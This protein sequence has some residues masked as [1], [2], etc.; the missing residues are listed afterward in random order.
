MVRKTLFIGMFGLSLLL[1]MTGCAEFAVRGSGGLVT[2]TYD[3]SGFNHLDVSSAV[4]VE[5]SQEGQES[6]SVETDANLLQYLEV[7]VR[8]ETL[9]VGLNDRARGVSISPS[10]GIT[11]T[12][13]VDD[14]ERLEVSGASDVAA[15]PLE[16]GDFV[17][18]VSG[19]SDVQIESLDVDSARI[20]ASGASDVSVGGLRAGKLDATA[21]GASTVEVSGEA[22]EQVADIEGASHYRASSLQ[23]EDAYVEASGASD[24]ELR[25]SETLGV[26]ASGA[27]SVGYYG[28]PQVS[29]QLSGASDLNRL[30]Q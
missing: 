21:S 11:F 9:Y 13:G 16:A 20:E 24:A 30:G 4:R 8:G 22:A 23:S 5:L 26:D 7:E 19:A 6:V 3:V 29:Q 28:D 27:S 14:L 2:E 15:G 10:R 12:V 18:S 25:A 17:L 1:V